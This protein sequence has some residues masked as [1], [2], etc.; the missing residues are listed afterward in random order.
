M[1]W[2]NFFNFE[3]AIKANADRR[4]QIGIEISNNKKRI[5]KN[6]KKQ[7]VLNDIIIDTED[8]LNQRPSRKRVTRSVL[9]MTPAEHQD[10]LNI[11]RGENDALL[12]ENTHLLD[13]TRNLQKTLGAL[14]PKVDLPIHSFP[15]GNKSKRNKSKRNKSN[16]NKSKRNKSKRNKSKRK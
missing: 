11:H 3:G 16:R 13:D 5:K 14:P 4:S 1:S 10:R 6:Q 12:D 8:M 7:A 15:G 9:M 2:F